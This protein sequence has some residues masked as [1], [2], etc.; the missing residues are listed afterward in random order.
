VIVHPGK[1]KYFIAIVPPPPIYEEALKWKTFFQANFNAKAALRSPPHIT[2]HMPFEWKSAK[3]N[4]LIDSLASFS[5]EC[6]SFPIELKNFGSFPPRVIFI[7][8]VENS[9]LRDLQKRLIQYCKS[10]LNLFNANRREQPYHPHLTVAFR[11]LKKSVFP[12]AWQ[13]VKDERFQHSFH[14]KSLALL[15]HT[16]KYWE[17]KTQLTFI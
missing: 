1:S 7:Q 4:L 3:E 17:V 5:N 13:V 6:K 2:L 16:G 8:V 15:K 14:C 10:E 11:D 12:N 9:E